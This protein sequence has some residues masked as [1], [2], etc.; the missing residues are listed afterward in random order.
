M[1]SKMISVIIPVYNVE[2][3]LSRCLDSLLAQTWTDWQ[4]IC[5]NDGSTDGS[6]AILERYAAADHRIKAISTP[7]GGASRARNIALDMLDTDYMMMLDS[8]DFLHPQAMEICMH[9]ALKDGSDLVTFNYSHAYRNRLILRHLLHL[10]DP[11]IHFRRYKPENIESKVSDD[12][13]QWATEYSKP[14]DIDRKWAIKHCQPWHCLYR[15]AK[16]RDLRFPEGIIYEDFPWWSAVL[17]RTDRVTI[18][19]APLYYYYPNFTGYILSSPQDYKVESLRK[20]IDSAIEF[21]DCEASIYKRKMWEKN[22]LTP[23]SDKLKKK[24]Q[25][26][27]A[28]QPKH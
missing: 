28:S 5:V 18:L 10:P 24:A 17:L 2:N 1:Q 22:F 9:F 11:K 14:K 19:R 4:A 23:F 25:A 8:D 16:I 3:Q 20:A 12:I 21:Y 15:V 6:A 27:A 13:Y 7:N 26:I